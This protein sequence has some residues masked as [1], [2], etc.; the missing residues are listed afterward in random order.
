MDV[1]RWVLEQL[2]A[3]LQAAPAEAGRPAYTI[4]RRGRA[5]LDR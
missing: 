1:T 2:L 3:S 5:E 4:F